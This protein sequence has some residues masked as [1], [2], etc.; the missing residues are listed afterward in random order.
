MKTLDRLPVRKKEVPPLFDPAAWRLRVDGLVEQSL[1]L[2][3]A[4]VQ[5]LPQTRLTSDFV[6]EE[7]F[8]VPDIK[9]EGVQVKRLAELARVNPEASWV[10]FYS[11]AFVVSLPLAEA[12]SEAT[13]LA[14]RMDGVTL[15]REHGAPLR[16][17][18]PVRGC[19][20]GVKWVDRLE[21]TSVER[22]DTGKGEVKNTG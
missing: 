10:A 18:E 11:G 1:S 12:L 16:L 9:W 22:L 6:C 17:V 20:Y 19:H 4:Q 13:I 8:Q 21:F 3:Y 15:P 14:Y 7:D 5:S 2:T